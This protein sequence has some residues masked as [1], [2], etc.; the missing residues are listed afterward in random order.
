MESGNAGLREDP[1][2][3]LV[4]LPRDA[5]ALSGGVHRAA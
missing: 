4:K 2:T 3:P 5:I 1:A